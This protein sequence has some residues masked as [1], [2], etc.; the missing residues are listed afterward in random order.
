MGNSSW[1]EGQ[2]ENNQYKKQVLVFKDVKQ[3]VK[4]NFSHGAKFQLRVKAEARQY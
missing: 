2:I 4:L 3:D 1:A